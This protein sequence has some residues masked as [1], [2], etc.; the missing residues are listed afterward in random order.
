MDS[1]DDKKL[2]SEFLDGSEI[3][4]KKLIDKYSKKITGML[5]EC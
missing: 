4:F 1:V 3:A 2:V 5:V